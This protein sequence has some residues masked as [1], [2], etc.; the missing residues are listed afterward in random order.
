M[1][2]L[3]IF[4]F[5]FFSLDI[6]IVIGKKEN[7]ERKKENIFQQFLCANNEIEMEYC[8]LTD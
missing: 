4:L 2:C 6:F 5:L 3:F 1:L 7:V 8:V